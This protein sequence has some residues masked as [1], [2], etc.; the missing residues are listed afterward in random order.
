MQHLSGL[1]VDDVDNDAS[2]PPASL[3]QVIVLVALSRVEGLVE[4][5]PRKLLPSM[6]LE[7][8]SGSHTNV[9]PAKV[10]VFLIT[11]IQSE[12]S[13]ESYFYSFS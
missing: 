3:E 10:T 4:E 7:C 13:D 1:R 2:V 9:L 12:N 11:V 8:P 5:S 6:D